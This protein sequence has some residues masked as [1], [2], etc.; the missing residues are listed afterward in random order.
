ML[1][2]FRLLFKGDSAS[3]FFGL[4]SLNTKFPYLIDNELIK[5]IKWD[6]Y[7]FEANPIFDEN[8]IELKKQLENNGQNVFLYNS[9]ASWV[10]DGFIEFYLDTINLKNNFYGSSLEFN[11]PDVI[12]SGVKKIRVPCKNVATILKKYSQ[13]DFI[14]VKIDIEGSEYEMLVH[15]LKENVLNLIDLMPIEY[16]TNVAKLITPEQTFNYIFKSFGVK[17]LQWV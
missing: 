12:K 4:D 16:H 2:I 7:L 9:T 13:S 3:G 1:I 5:K 14:V 8:L 11:H 6:V 15:L 17:L 10:Y